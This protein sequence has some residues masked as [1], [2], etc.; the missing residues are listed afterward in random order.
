MGTQM[1][2][3]AAPLAVP[4]VVLTLARA[5]ADEGMWTLDSFPAARIEK[6]YGF[7]PDQAW[8]D[9]VRLSSVR[10]AFGCSASFVS[11]LGLV[12]TNHHCAQGCI[13][14]LSTRTD[15]LVA[16]G[17]YAKT[18]Q[19]EPKCPNLEVNQ[20][21]AISD[22]TTRVNA[23]TAGLDGKALVDA[24]RA[25]EATIA[26]ECSG[27]DAN[28]RCDVVELYHGGIYNLYRYRRY[29]DVHL[30]FAP[31]AAIAFFGGDPDN[32]EF[33]R[34]DLDVTYLRVYEDERPLDTS[35][36]FLRYAA[37]DA[38]PGDLTFTSGHPRRTNRLNTVAE[39]AFQRDV[40]LPRNIFYDSE[41]RG[42]RTSCKTV[43]RGVFETLYEV[44]RTRHV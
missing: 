34:Y 36:N 39:L 2:L 32:F 21:T 12:Q 23:A 30:V 10:L 14:Q 16:A 27:G 28:T 29:Q 7:A 25:V 8:L 6:A 9:H 19:D 17:F 26:R 5:P 11:P 24:K 15:D 33:P 35:A 3:S 18:V 20:L 44:N 1:R 43:G 22:I 40:T 41:L 42:M 38:R 4:L 13:A 31:E 37:R